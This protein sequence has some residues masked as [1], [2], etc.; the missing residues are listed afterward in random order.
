MTIIQPIPAAQAGQSTSSHTSPLSPEEQ[1]RLG[2]CEATVTRGLHA[3]IEVGSALME[4]RDHRLYR[5]DYGT[6][7]TYCTQRW[8]ITYRR[9]NQL[10]QAVHIVQE[11][12]AQGLREWEPVVPIE[13]VRGNRVPIQERQVRELAK[14]PPEER[15]AAWQEAVKSAPRKAG[16]PK[17]TVK[18]VSAAVRRRLSP[19]SVPARS[20]VSDSETLRS[21]PTVGAPTR[22]VDPPPQGRQTYPVRDLPEAE[23]KARYPGIRALLWEDDIE[24]AAQAQWRELQDD[25]REWAAL[26]DSPLGDYF[27]DRLAEGSLWLDPTSELGELVS[28]LADSLSQ[29]RS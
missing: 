1:A 27:L 25:P 23:L 9:A 24:T 19:T 15:V 29:V 4:I 2:A 20:N 13:G 11:M 26:I 8:E 5:T 21:Q 7:E 16:Q 3:F 6:F 10:I 14:L 28:L 22:L 18:H 17:V 12:E